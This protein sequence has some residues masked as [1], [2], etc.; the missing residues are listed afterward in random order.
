M[1]FCTRKPLRLFDGTQISSGFRNDNKNIN[2]KNDINIHNSMHTHVKA[3][4]TFLNKGTAKLKKKRKK[5][6]GTYKSIEGTHQHP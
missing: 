3:F 6:R 2:K 5:K 4:S 1:Y